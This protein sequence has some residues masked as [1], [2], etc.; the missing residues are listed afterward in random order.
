MMNGRNLAAR[1]QGLDGEAE[2][3]LPAFAAPLLTFE[4]EKPPGVITIVAHQ[5]P[6]ICRTSEH[7]T[8]AWKPFQAPFQDN[9]QAVQ[10]LPARF[11]Q[12]DR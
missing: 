5:K 10:R 4:I 1:R 6:P 8:A 2:E 11:S 3:V 12:D 7:A 9:R